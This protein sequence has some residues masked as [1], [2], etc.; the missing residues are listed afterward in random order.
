[1]APL[2]SAKGYAITDTKNYTDF[3]VKEYKLKTAESHDVD[4]EIECCG[5]CGSVSYSPC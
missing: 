3:S 4:I 5:V 2:Q 1:M